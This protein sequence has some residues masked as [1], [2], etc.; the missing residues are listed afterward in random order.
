MK[1]IEKRYWKKVVKTS[2]C[3]RWTGS[4]DRHGYGQMRIN[5]KLQQAHRV[6]WE[7]FNGKIPLGMC[8]LHYCDNPEC[9]RID[10]LRLGTLKENSKDMI[11]KGRG[12]GQWSKENPPVYYI[13]TMCPNGHPKTGKGDCAVCSKLRNVEYRKRKLANRPLL[14]CPICGEKFP[15]YHKR[16][17]CSTKC[18][19]TASNRKRQAKIV[20]GIPAYEFREQDWIDGVVLEV[21]A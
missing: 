12:R 3:W 16:K 15:D 7:I 9:T 4:K 13:K 17:Y 1:S 2:S 6:A 14:I 8:V 18:H 10:H 19:W 5:Q 20:C 21:L 11:L